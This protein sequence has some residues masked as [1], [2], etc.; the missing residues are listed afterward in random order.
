[1][2]CIARDRDRARSC[3]VE[4]RARDSVVAA[5]VLEPNADRRR[6]WS[7]ELVVDG[8]G[9]PPEVVARLAK[10]GLTVLRV[11]PQGEYTHAVAVV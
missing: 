4:C 9:L 10:H 11:A 1:M 7:L 2:A 8:A 3:A 6:T 5:D